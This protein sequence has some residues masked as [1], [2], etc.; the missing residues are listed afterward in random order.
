LGGC[1]SGNDDA[2]GE[3]GRKK[4]FHQHTFTQLLTATLAAGL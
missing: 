1:H 3:G 2:S 4:L